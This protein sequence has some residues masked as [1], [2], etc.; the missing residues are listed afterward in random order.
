MNE[1]L[2]RSLGTLCRLCGEQK[3]L[4]NSHIIPAFVFRDL[5]SQ[6]GTGHIRFTENPNVRVQDGVKVPWLCEGCEQRFSAWERK[7][8]NEVV[9][10]W[11]EGRERTR[12]S[13]WMLKFC[14]SLSWRVLLYVKGTNAERSYSDDEEKGFA[15]AEACWREFLLDQRPHP[16]KFEHH[17][18][19]WDVAENTD[20]PDL[21]T[22]FNRF[23]L[24]AVLM[25]I[26]GSGHSTYVWSKLGRFQIF[27]TIEHGPNK[28]EGTKV[29]VREGVLKPGRV[30]LPAGLLDLYREKADATREAYSR[31]SEA[32]WDKI[33]ATTRANID[34]FA[35]S[36]T[37]RA[38]QADAAMFG[39]DAILRRSR[40]S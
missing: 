38:M 12:Y 2:K 32:Q 10:E 17:F 9:S 31:L 11:N 34:R 7:F 5:K 8:A 20:I 39:E 22:N 16:G 6:S 28:W 19:A 40:P 25:D 36:R 29:H 37:F 1:K 26:V 18:I 30:V 3:P 15:A 13:E 33:D 35:G 27:G 4:K 21:P 23:M 14:V 24:G